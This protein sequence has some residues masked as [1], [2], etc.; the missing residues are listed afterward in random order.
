MADKNIAGIL[1][2][3]KRLIFKFYMLCEL[4]ILR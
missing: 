3:R 2:E 1:Q 4:K